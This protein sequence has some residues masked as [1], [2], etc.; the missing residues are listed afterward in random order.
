MT[1]RINR[2]P[3]LSSDYS[4]MDRVSYFPIMALPTELF[5]RVMEYLQ[6]RDVAT[7]IETSKTLSVKTLSCINQVLKKDTKN[8]SKELKDKATQTATLRYAFFLHMIPYLNSKGDA[9]KQ[10][11]IRKHQTTPIQYQQHIEHELTLKIRPE[12]LE[13]LCTSCN[14]SQ[15][16]ITAFFALILHTWKE[17]WNPLCNTLPP[18]IDLIENRI[19]ASWQQTFP[20]LAHEWK[21][22]CEMKSVLENRAILINRHVIKKL[23]ILPSQ[24]L[25]KM[26]THQAIKPFSRIIE[27]TMFCKNPINLNLFTGA[28]EQSSLSKQFANLCLPHIKS[29][30]ID[31]LFQLLVKERA[32]ALLSAMVR[33]NAPPSMP[34]FRAAFSDAVD[35]LDIDLLCSLAEKK[36]LSG[37]ALEES[38]IQTLEMEDKP[39][40]DHEKIG[41]IQSILISNTCIED[42]GFEDM[43]LQA[44]NNEDISLI[45]ILLTRPSIPQKTIDNAIIETAAIDEEGS[46]M[47]KILKILKMLLHHETPISDEARGIAL[48][49]IAENASPKLVKLVLDSGA[50]STERRNLAILNSAKVND[51]ASLKL[52]LGQNSLEAETLTACLEAT[53]ER[54]CIEVLDFL[55]AIKKQISQQELDSFTTHFIQQGWVTDRPV[56]TL[57]LSKG[58]ISASVRDILISEVEKWGPRVIGKDEVLKQLKKASITE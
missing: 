38:L 14:L 41:A 15:L 6:P 25:Q 1:S 54:G 21:S 19:D 32:Y 34:E 12:I 36:L 27:L 57:L 9:V 4:T 22:L 33:S 56:L 16:E 8:L 58:T 24:A 23:M 7:L 30:A 20:P 50:V 49:E 52:I 45:R 35:Q 47:L 53:I 46:D 29:D 48:E 2:Q 39:S 11:I 55:L 51:L 3:Q 26:T 10:L 40:A 18:E 31:P 5:F 13:V 28:E 37:E 42:S 43:L 17:G 44:I